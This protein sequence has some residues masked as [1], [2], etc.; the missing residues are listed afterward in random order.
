MSSRGS[1]A[2]ACLLLLAGCDQSA[3]PPPPPPPAPATPTPRV[4]LLAP[5]GERIAEARR[6][7]AEAGFPDGKGF[8]KLEVLYNTAEWHK[9]IAAAIQEMW[10][11]RLGIQV[12]LRNMEWKVYLDQVQKGEFDIARRGYFGEYIDPEALLSL[13]TPDSGFNSGGWN[14]AEYNRLIAA[15]DREPDPSKRFEQLGRAE[16]I[17]VDET[18]LVPLYNYLGH[19]LI[20]PFI[21]GV[22]HNIRELHPLQGVT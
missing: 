8:P 3:A 20:K 13:F 16:R 2:A 15:A 12:E 11:Q 17:L 14:S 9:K 10:R 19:N 1:V 4:S 18:P 21:K 22:H 5:A 7:L 6:L